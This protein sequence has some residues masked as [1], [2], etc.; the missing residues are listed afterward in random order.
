MTLF[1]DI[2]SDFDTLRDTGLISQLTKSITFV[3]ATA[4][5]RFH[6]WVI[7]EFDSIVLYSEVLFETNFSF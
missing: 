7:S 1:L 5:V 6:R 4:V 2:T 3:S